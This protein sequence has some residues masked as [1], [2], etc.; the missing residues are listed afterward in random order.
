M[1]EGSLAVFHAATPVINTRDQFH[2]YQQNSNFYYLTGI[3][4]PGAALILH[5][6]NR[7]GRI[8][9]L[10]IPKPDASREV[11]EGKMTDKEEA[12]EISGVEDVR[13]IKDFEGAFLKA[14]SGREIVYVDYED[15]GLS[16]PTSG[17]T[18]FIDKVHRSLPGLQL[19]KAGLI[20]S[21]LR[22]K[23][24]AEEV[25]MIR[26]AIDITRE[27]LM[28]LWDDVHSGK[29][30]YE[31]EATLAY[32]FLRRRARQYAYDP[33]I[34]SGEN[35]TV[36]HYVKNNRRLED[37]DLLLTDVGAQYDHYCADITRTI[38]VN[39]RYSP[40]QQEIY[41]AVL[42]VQ[43]SVIRQ[44][45]PGVSFA[46]LKETGKE[47][48]GETLMDLELIGAMDETSEYYMHSIGHLLG[49]DTHDVGDL[50]APLEPGN[51]LTTEPGIYIREEGL[52]VRIEDDLLVTEDGCEVLSK[53]IPKEIGEIERALQG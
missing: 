25:N 29:Y 4:T 40:R 48:I 17:H 14:Q 52:G 1:E 27:A 39:G 26:E 30:E 5:P 6:E 9:S 38:P 36:L 53:A 23:K 34:A 33:I 22:R 35:T 15:T 18:G 42:D 49:L 37:G 13:Y 45:R 47:L 11:W 51:V 21:S 7:K 50:E 46:E 32:H 10:F 3:E 24:S 44:V 2:R 16:Y 41:Q 43:K 8:A 31:L 20:L 12:G 28:A 19:R